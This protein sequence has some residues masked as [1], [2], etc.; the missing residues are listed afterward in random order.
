MC[1]RLPN[2]E[3]RREIDHLYRKQYDLLLLEQYQSA[4]ELMS[5]GYQKERSVEEFSKDFR[6]LEPASVTRDIDFRGNAACF[7]VNGYEW[8]TAGARYELVKEE[9]SWRF[10]GKYDYL[11]D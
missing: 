11:L 3:N 8:L 10:T 1:P 7:Y 9:E 2:R 4:Y 5:S 6:R